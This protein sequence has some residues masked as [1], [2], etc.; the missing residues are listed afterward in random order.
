VQRESFSIAKGLSYKAQ[1]FFGLWGAFSIAD[2]G[3]DLLSLS[4]LIELT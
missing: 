3:L 4:A 1:P 2:K